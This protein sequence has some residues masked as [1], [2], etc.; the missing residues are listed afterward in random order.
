ML[1][2]V[3]QEKRIEASNCAL[4]T[5][6]NSRIERRRGGWY[7]CWPSRDGEEISR[8][9][10]CKRGQDFYPVWYSQWGQG[11]TAATALSQLIR[12]CAAKPVLSLTTWRYWASDRV[13]LLPEASVAILEKAGYPN[14][15]RCVLCGEEIKSSVDWWSLL[16]V[17]GPCCS[18]RSGCRQGIK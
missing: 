3:E 5:F 2:P 14:V 9:W 17:S 12:W 8:R 15:A 1:T 7:V 6:T 11:G 16:K 18:W 4:I 10:C 13:Q